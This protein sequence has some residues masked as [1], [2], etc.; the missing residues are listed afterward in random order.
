MLLFGTVGL[1]I[2]GGDEPDCGEEVHA[3]RMELSAALD[4][5]R[6]SQLEVV[7]LEE[8][9]DDCKQGRLC[10]LLLF[11]SDCVLQMFA[12]CTFRSNRVAA[13]SPWH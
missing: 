6:S 9:L 7:R 8:E 4:K 11:P 10:D 1:L 3:L 12:Y 2:T 5:L 13:Q